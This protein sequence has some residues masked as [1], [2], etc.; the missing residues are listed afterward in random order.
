[1]D[2]HKLEAFAGGGGGA[3]RTDD[4]LARLRSPAVS[5]MEIEAAAGGFSCGT[6]RFA[7]PSA[8][9]C[10]HR[11]VD[12]PVSPDHGCCNLWAGE[13]VTFPPDFKLPK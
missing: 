4:E 7:D 6:C 3:E 12:A 1:M 11:K 10:T 13:G 9:R 8:R 5:Y 2:A